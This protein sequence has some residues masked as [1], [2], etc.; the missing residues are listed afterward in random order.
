MLT[1]NEATLGIL[2]TLRDDATGQLKNFSGQLRTT[3]AEATAMGPRVTAPMND[4]SESMVKNRAA[5]RELS[6]GVMFL[7]TTF[8]SLGVSMKMTNN[9]TL[10]NIGNIIMISGAIMTAVGSA[11][12]FISAITKVIDALKKLR[13]AEILTQAFSGPAGWATLAV[14]GAIAAGT[15][16]SL[17]KMESAST[18]VTRAQNAAAGSTTVNVNVAGSVVTNRQLVDEVH[19][20]LL[21]KEQRSSTTGIK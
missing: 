18:R 21:L 3:G 5:I 12:Q 15:I 19:R 1:I 2:L 10:Q 7:G 13:A 4:I 16:A 6:M 11:A 17:S 8:M 9:E 20:G 14:G